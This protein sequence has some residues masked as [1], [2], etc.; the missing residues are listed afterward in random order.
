MRPLPG[1]VAALLLA[2]CARLPAP[3]ATEP[4]GPAYHAGG[5]QWDDGAGLVFLVRTFERNDRVA[6]CG[7]RT[8]VSTTARTL[9]LN[10]YVAGVAVLRLDGDRIHQGLRMLPDARYRPDMTGA[11]ARCYL[12][13]RPWRAGYAA[14][15]PEIRIAR[16]QFDEGGDKGF[17]AGDAV[18]FRQSPVSRP[19]P[20][21]GAAR[22]AR[23]RP[24]PSAA[25]GA[26]RT[27]CTR[28]SAC[29]R[30]AGRPRAHRRPRP[31]PGDRR[32]AGAR[33]RCCPPPSRAH[34]RARP[35]SPAAR[36]RVRPAR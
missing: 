19:L 26:L 4:V 9:Y 24:A 22:D 20:P 15:R 34:A 31:S 13:D 7:V 14:A 2:A 36:R 3:L 23:P 12:T 32:R 33:P 11:T 18:V 28:R 1:L 29:R 17:G 25:S 5:G 16:M 27:S 35:S 6:F 10:D 8:E 30:S 21:A